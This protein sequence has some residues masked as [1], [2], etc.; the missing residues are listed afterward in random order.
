MNNYFKASDRRW[1]D[2]HDD[3]HPVDRVVFVFCAVCFVILLA[4]GFW[5]GGAA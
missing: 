1:V 4:C 2:H 5:F 3:A